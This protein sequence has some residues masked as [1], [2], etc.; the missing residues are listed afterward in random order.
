MNNS[1]ILSRLERLESRGIFNQVET[2]SLEEKLTLAKEVFTKYYNSTDSEQ[3]EF[4]D[5]LNQACRNDDKAFTH[6][7]MIDCSE[8]FRIGEE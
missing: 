6:Q 2:L 5:E 3:Q 8:S 4:L 7:N 1:K